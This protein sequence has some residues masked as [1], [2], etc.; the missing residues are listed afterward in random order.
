MDVNKTDIVL[1]EDNME[2]AELTIRAVKKNNVSD[3]LVHLKDGEQALDFIFCRGQYTGRN[4]NDLPR[5]ILLDIKMPKVDGLEVLQQIKSS[6]RTKIIPVVLFTSSK[7]EKDILQSYQL[8]A[9]S[10]IVKPVDFD[11]FQKVVSELCSYWLQ[12]NQRLNQ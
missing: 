7:E 10:Y 5:L 1:V 8:G 2:D 4:R 12:V 11:G 3:S 6:S 9:N